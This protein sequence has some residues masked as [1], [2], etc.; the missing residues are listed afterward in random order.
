M[1][2]SDVLVVHAIVLLG[3]VVP[4]LIVQRPVLAAPPGGG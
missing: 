4:V 1:A 3:L 2:F